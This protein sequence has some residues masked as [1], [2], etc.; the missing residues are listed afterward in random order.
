MN[1]RNT[2]ESQPSSEDPLD[3]DRK[4]IAKELKKANKHARKRNKLMTKQYQ[5]SL[6]DHELA[7][8][9]Y[10]IEKS[11]LQPKFTLVVTE[12]LTC[13]PDFVND[14]EQASEAKFLADHGVGAEQQAL[15]FRVE[16]KGGADYMRPNIVIKQLGEQADERAYCMSER[17]FFIDVASLDLSESATSTVAYFVY[18]DRTTLPVV[19]KY[20]L[21]QRTGSALL[22]WDATHVDTVYV[23]SDQMSAPINTSDECA[24]LF[25]NSV[26]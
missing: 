1:K 10:L 5:Q 7:E 17:T 20:R 22:R 21:N 6:L 19:H 24:E 13:E 2:Q 14:P 9:R 11:A 16:A 25:K 15:R 4:S 18:R 23:K 26:Y 8:R 12:F 3:K